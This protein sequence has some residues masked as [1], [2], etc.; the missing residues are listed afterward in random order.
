LTVIAVAVATGITSPF[1]LGWHQLEIVAFV[2]LV[3][4]VLELCAHAA[5]LADGHDHA[6]QG[7]DEQIG[8][9]QAELAQLRES[10]EADATNAEHAAAERERTLLAELEEAREVNENV[11]LLET[12]VLSLESERNQLTAQL[13]SPRL[14]LHE[15]LSSIDQQIGVIDIIAKHRAIEEEAGAQWAVTDIQTDDDAFVQITAH[16][17]SHAEWMPNEWVSLINASDQ[18]IIAN[19]QVT[20]SAGHVMTALAGIEQLPEWL[21]SQLYATGIV[22]PTGMVVRLMGLTLVPYRDMDDDG[23]VEL[24]EALRESARTINDLLNP[25]PTLLLESE[26]LDG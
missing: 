22:N 2:G 24:R 9:L 15:V 19:A 20:A 7:R 11:L 25:S 26:E 23:L 13:R 3:V 16:I 21:Q 8:S 14:S 6:L 5:R 18:S 10:A 1:N 17:E 12:Q 4:L